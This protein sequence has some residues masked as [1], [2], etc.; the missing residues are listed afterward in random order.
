MRYAPQRAIDVIFA[1]SILGIIGIV[2]SLGMSFVDNPKV[3]D[4]LL[5]PNETR[6]AKLAAGYKLYP[7]VGWVSPAEQNTMEPIYRVHPVTG[8]KVLDLDAML[9]VQK[10]LKHCD[11]KTKL[12]SGKIPTWNLDGSINVIHGVGLFYSNDTHSIDNTDCEWKKI[13][14]N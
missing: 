6:D 1:F 5:I 2:F 3:T 8:E 10:I 9:A 12:E 13:N 7:G 14:E 4:S 11:Y